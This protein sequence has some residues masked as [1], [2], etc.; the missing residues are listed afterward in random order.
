MKILLINRAYP[1]HWRCGAS[2]WCREVARAL[3]RRGHQIKVLTGDGSDHDSAAKDLEGTKGL[4]VERTLKVRR[5][6]PLLG[7]ISEYFWVR[8]NVKV[9]KNALTSFKPDVV[10]CWDLEGLPVG[11]LN[12]TRKSPGVAFS[13][14]SK[15]WV[16]WSS[17]DPWLSFWQGSG[18]LL[19]KM[20]RMGLTFTGIR[21]L[22]GISAPTYL[23]KKL[24][25]RHVTFGSAYLRN[26]AVLAGFPLGRSPIVPEGINPE[27]YTKK[28]VYTHPVRLVWVGSLE[29]SQSP[30][31]VLDALASLHRKK[32]AFSLTMIYTCGVSRLKKIGKAIAARGLENVVELRTWQSEGF[33]K[34]L[35]DYDGMIYSSAEGEVRG[36]FPYQAAAARLPLITSFSGDDL[37]TIRE[38]DNCMTFVPGD[39]DSLE[40][41]ILSL[42]ALPDHGEQLAKR[43]FERVKSQHD[44]WLAIDRIEKTLDATLAGEPYQVAAELY[45]PTGGYRS[46]KVPPANEKLP[47]KGLR[48]IQL[49]T[50]AEK[51]KALPDARE[52]Q[53]R[54]SLRSG[55][56]VDISHEQPSLNQE[57]ESSSNSSRFFKENL[58]WQESKK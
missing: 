48:K 7:S 8:K 29:E 3:A 57:H 51:S 31:I 19:G 50:T 21:S 45:Q 44:Y 6:S 30:E 49:K 37:E 38:G 54:L 9:V 4:A 1:P 20:F 42:A 10:Y 39:A 25:V 23:P 16:S 55:K 12:V 13:V 52:A 15:N 27:F 24:D 17:R 34:R 5:N 26:N 40:K 53:P 35:A 33:E 43:N 36:L 2:L 46:A 47:Q 58:E 14:F 22:I 18:S 11:I 41:A 56:K 32:H 28:K